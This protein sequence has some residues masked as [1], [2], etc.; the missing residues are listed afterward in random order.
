MSAVIE[1][2]RPVRERA[3]QLLA[4]RGELASLLHKGAEK[5]RTVAA[6][7]LQRAYD[8]VGLLPR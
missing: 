3:T 5:A 4:D 2:L 8:A 7:T 1:A 6:A